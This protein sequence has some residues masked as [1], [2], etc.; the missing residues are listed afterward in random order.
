[1]KEKRKPINPI[2]VLRFAC[3]VGVI[4]LWA[5]IFIVWPQHAGYTISIFLVTFVSCVLWSVV[6]ELGA[7]FFALLWEMTSPENE[8]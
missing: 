7:E 3:L 2:H 4:P 6:A 5:F 8:D 1:M